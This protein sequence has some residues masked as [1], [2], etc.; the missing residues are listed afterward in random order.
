MTTVTIEKAKEQLDQLI[1]R[2]RAGEEIVIAGG[3]EPGVRLQVVV[4]E[5]DADVVAEQRG[6]RSRGFGLLKGK[7]ETPPDS[8]FFD[9][10]PDDELKLWW[11]EDA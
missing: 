2:A 11:G 6:R 3:S 10:L 5:S 8:A 9:P 4:R 7:M 1:A